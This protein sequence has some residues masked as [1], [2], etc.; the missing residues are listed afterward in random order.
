MLR[1]LLVGQGTNLHTLFLFLSILGG[2]A[3]Y[4]V[5][6]LFL[7]PLLLTMSVTAVQIYEEEYREMPAPPR[8]DKQ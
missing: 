1:P 2:L 4:G 7:G 6:G 3:A 5:I 8:A